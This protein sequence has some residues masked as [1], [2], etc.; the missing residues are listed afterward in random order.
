[1][2]QTIAQQINWDFEA[3]GLLEI[4]NK[5][6]KRIYAES[7]RYW[8]K[9]E[10]DSEGN[11]IYYEN[12]NRFWRKS[13]YDSQGNKVYYENSHGAIIDNRHKPSEDSIV[14]IDGVKYRLTKL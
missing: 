12:S 11:E 8:E 5:N 13:K 10:Y 7:K 4:R 6:G 2:K 1:M 3:N 9:R 14:E